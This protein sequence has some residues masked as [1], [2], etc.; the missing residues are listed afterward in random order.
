MKNIS[1]QKTKYPWH[2]AAPHIP[3]GTE[4]MCE[5]TIKTGEIGEIY[6]S[7]LVRYIHTGIYRLVNFGAEKS[8]DQKIA[9]AFV[10][11]LKEDVEQ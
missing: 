3:K 8:C 1:W 6:G 10:D 11:S 5:N 7:V 4:L 2:L 9:Q